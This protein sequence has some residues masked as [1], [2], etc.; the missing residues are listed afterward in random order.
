MNRGARPWAT[1]HCGGP[2]CA[3]GLGQTETDGWM[4]VTLEDQQTRHLCS[5]RCALAFIEAYETARE[6]RLDANVVRGQLAIAYVVHP[7]TREPAR[8]R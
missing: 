3:L 5:A 7:P 4:A 2:D 8:V 6:S 1:L